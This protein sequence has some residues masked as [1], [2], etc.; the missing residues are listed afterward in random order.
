MIAETAGINTVGLAVLRALAHALVK[1]A[2]T[3]STQV[4]QRTL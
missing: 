3:D 1:Y 2:A 4:K